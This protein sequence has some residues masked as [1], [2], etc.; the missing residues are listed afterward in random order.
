MIQ[1][2]KTNKECS[3]AIKLASKGDI[4]LFIEGQEGF[5]MSSSV[6]NWVNQWQV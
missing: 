5:G 4:I 6:L 2:A 3:E 1:Y